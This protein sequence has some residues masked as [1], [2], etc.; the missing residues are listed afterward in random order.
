MRKTFLIL[1]EK[2]TKPIKEKYKGKT[3]EKCRLKR[4]RVEC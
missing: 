2:V 4:E 3:E 1:E